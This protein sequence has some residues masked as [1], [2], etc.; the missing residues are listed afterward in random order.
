[1]VQRRDE[2]RICSRAKFAPI[3]RNKSLRIV[4][5]NRHFADRF[6]KVAA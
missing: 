2:A 3:N 6:A 5:F 1:M 4:L